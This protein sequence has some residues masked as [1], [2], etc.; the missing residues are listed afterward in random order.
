MD[1]SDLMEMMPNE[2]KE[3]EDRPGNE[4]KRGERNRLERPTRQTKPGQNGT[5][6]RADDQE[7]AREIPDA[8]N[9]PETGEKMR[10][11]ERSE[12]GSAPPH[13]KYRLLLRSV[14]TCLSSN[15]V[16]CALV[17]GYGLLGA[18][19]FQ[20]LEAEYEVVVRERG[21]RLR[22]QTLASMYNATAQMNLLKEGNWTAEMTVLLRQYEEALLTT[23]S[24]E[25]FDG[26]DPD[27]DDRKWSFSAALFFSVAVMT[28][29]GWFHGKSI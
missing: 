6:N 20:T 8:L 28:T 19:V 15:A 25:G 4:A 7:S 1:R 9:D 29:I 17:A 23:A 11:S 22:S 13:G 12:S 24:R 27:S 16:L 2:K 21:A 3:S 26:L 18:F 5:S 14:M 10:D